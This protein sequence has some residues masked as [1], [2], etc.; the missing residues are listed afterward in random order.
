ML[1]V[2]IKIKIYLFRQI[3]SSTLQKYEMRRNLKFNQNLVYQV[4]SLLDPS[5][6]ETAIE[7]TIKTNTK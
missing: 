3:I 1:S 5:K 6:I 2:K 7:S 4:Q